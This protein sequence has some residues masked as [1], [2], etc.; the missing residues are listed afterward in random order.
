M[1]GALVLALA[2]AVAPPVSDRPAWCVS[3]YECL[4]THEIVAA[5]EHL[6]DLE[7]TIGVLRA[8]A[9]GHRLGWHAGCGPGATLVVDADWN[10][11][12]LPAPLFCGGVY[13]W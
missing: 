8:K 10:T 12:V 9:K 13:G 5:T 4:P 2:A 6:I 3:G 11:K 1:I 7:E